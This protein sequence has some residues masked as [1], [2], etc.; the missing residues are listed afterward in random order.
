MLAA[1]GEPDEKVKAI[2]INRIF[3]MKYNQKQ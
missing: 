1:S 3:E 2:P